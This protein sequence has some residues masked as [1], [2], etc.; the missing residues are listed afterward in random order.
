MERHYIHIADFCK[1][2]YIEESF[3][4]ELFEYELISLKIDNEQKLIHE[5]EL[6]RLEKMVRLHR[7]LQ[8]N[9]EGLDAIH[10]LLQKNISLQAEIN[11]LR[12]QLE[13]YKK[14]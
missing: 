3:I 7:D 6:P 5:E 12:K 14:P 10:H 13:R 8:I 11:L 1:N 2:H 9:V 4:Y